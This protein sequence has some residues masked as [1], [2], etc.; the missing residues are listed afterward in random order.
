MDK[1][2]KW[3]FIL[4]L[5]IGIILLFIGIYIYIDGAIVSEEELDHTLEI[6]YHQLNGV[7]TI[8]LSL[9]ILIFSRKTYQMYRSEVKYVISSKKRKGIS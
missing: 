5:F 7:S 6:N 3:L 1:I 2:Y 4:N 8:I 9:I